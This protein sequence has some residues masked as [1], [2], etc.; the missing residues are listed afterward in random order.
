MNEIISHDLPRAFLCTLTIS[1]VSCDVDATINKVSTFQQHVRFTWLI[2]VT[3]NL[4]CC[5]GLYLTN[6]FRERDCSGFIDQRVLNLDIWAPIFN[7]CAV[8]NHGN[9]LIRR[10][11]QPINEPRSFR[12]AGSVLVLRRASAHTNQTIP[13]MPKTFPGVVIHGPRDVKVE[14]WPFPTIDTSTPNDAIVKVT[15]AGTHR[16]FE[17]DLGLCGSDLHGTSGPGSPGS[18]KRD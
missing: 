7:P 8:C 4:D 9:Y 15:A 5:L 10:H 14:D 13:T 18:V 12:C 17:T 3:S 11:T 6:P 1:G 2:L 16:H